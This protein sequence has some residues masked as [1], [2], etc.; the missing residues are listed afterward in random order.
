M[1]S[2]NDRV[3]DND[4][5]SILSNLHLVCLNLTMRV[6]GLCWLSG[7]G[8]LLPDITIPGSWGSCHQA[9]GLTD[10]LAFG[11]SGRILSCFVPPIK[12]LSTGHRKKVPEM[13][14]ASS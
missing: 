9:S 14:K 1:Q 6:S 10:L 4:R 11:I 3:H 8:M 5:C 7:A 13:L 12:S 2:M